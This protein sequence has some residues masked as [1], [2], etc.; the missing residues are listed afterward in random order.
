MKTRIKNKNKNKIE[1]YHHQMIEN[2]EIIC[3]TFL[4]GA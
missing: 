3:L 1:K 2:N 4:A